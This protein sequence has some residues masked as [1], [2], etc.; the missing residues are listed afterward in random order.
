MA[1]SADSKQ[2]NKLALIGNFLPRQCGLATFTTDVFEAMRARFPEVAVDVYAMDDHP[3]LYAY[4]PE[5]TCAI[6]ERDLSAYV[7]AARRI[8]A[9]GAQAIWLQ[10][11]YGI[12]G[13]PAGEHILALLDRT[14]LPLIVTLHTV[15]EEPNA[16]QRRVMEGL[17]RRAAKV[18]VM[19]EK[20]REILIRVYAA[21]PRQI[22]TIA[23]G[24][25]DRALVDPDTFKARF[26]WA[27]REV[28][29]TFGLLSP[30]KGIETVIQALPRIA[31]A[32]PAEG[33]LMA[34]WARLTRR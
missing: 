8:E 2:I 23:H 26:G 7:D 12:F 28:V 34:C 15:L 33:Y 25:P 16:D 14:T 1:R 17:L 5:V 27:G 13:G 31:Q 18:V 3:G 30:G 9:S 4:P 22:A 24:V 32:N 11:E 21:N 6:A 20:G 19:A 10:H 29:L